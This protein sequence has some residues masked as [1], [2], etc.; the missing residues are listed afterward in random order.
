MI[1]SKYFPYT[2]SA[3]NVDPS[4]FPKMAQQQPTPIFYHLGH[5]LKI[6]VYG[7]EQK[8]CGRFVGR[9]VAYRRFAKNT[10]TCPSHLGAIR[11]YSGWFQDGSY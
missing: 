8:T 10:V 9:K 2:P 1:N 6:M 4:K 5:V 3:D 7:F 11:K